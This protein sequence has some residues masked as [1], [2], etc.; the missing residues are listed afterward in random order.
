MVGPDLCLP[1]EARSARFGVCGG[2]LYFGKAASV[3]VVRRC[4]GLVLSCGLGSS[5]LPLFLGLCAFYVMFSVLFLLL[6]R[7]SLVDMCFH[8]PF[9]ARIGHCFCWVVMV[10]RHAWVP[11]SCP[12][13]SRSFLV[14]F[15]LF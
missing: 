9:K 4:V 7:V 1:V 3:S 2:P 8:V 11:D 14:Q 5:M 6:C 12:R 10:H 15:S 13:F